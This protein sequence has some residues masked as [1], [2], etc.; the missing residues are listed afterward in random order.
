MLIAN[1]SR[2]NIYQ[3]V[4]LPELCSASS[5]KELDPKEPLGLNRLEGCVFSSNRKMAV[6]GTISEAQRCRDESLPLS[7]PFPHDDNAAATSLVS[8]SV[9]QRGRRK[10]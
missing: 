9:F 4:N 7:Y 3:G 6:P 2:S 10:P 1:I 8:T 5:N